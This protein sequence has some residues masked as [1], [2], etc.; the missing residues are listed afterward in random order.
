M[1]L[2]IKY[3]ATFQCDFASLFLVG[4]PFYQDHEVDQRSG[5]QDVRTWSSQRSHA[6]IDAS[7]NLPDNYMCN[8]AHRL[9]GQP[10]RP[11]IKVNKWRNIQK[12]K[13]LKPWN[14]FAHIRPTNSKPNSIL[15][16]HCEEYS[17]QRL[18]EL[19]TKK[20]TSQWKQI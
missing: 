3:F 16:M 15:H 18:R 9:Q 6:C 10:R 5:S 1:I 4:G 11:Q 7:L 20:Y 2:N 14:V 12:F 8:V 17:N 19:L 13:D